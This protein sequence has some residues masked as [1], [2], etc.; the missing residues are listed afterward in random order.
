[1][2]VYPTEIIF[3][4]SVNMPEADSVTVGGAIDLTRRIVFADLAANSAVDFVSSS[5]ADTAVHVQVSG[6]DSGGVIQTPAFVTLTGTTKVTSQAQVFN[7]LLAGVA[8]GATATG[9]LANPGGTAA[10][11]DVAVLSRTL[12]IAAHA[13]QAGSANSTG[14]TPALFHLQSGDGSSLTLGMVIHTTGGTGANQLRRICSTSG[15]G[16]GQY[17]TDMVAINRDWA[18]VPDTTTTYEVATGF[19]FEILPDPVSSI[20]R[21]LTAAT[22]DIVGG[23]T[24]VY[25]EKIFAL[26][27]DLATTLTAASII[28]QTDPAGLYSGGGA[29]DFALCTALNDTATATNRQ[30]LPTGIGAFSSGAAPQSITCPN[31]LPFG[32]TPAGAQG[33]WLRLTLPPGEAPANTNFTLRATGTTT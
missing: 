11:G 15:T 18:V 22:S 20:V 21:P 12:T 3:C 28:K 29:L 31:N 9:P 10:V 32:N 14:V 17:G 6:R 23:S 2:S 13:A 5:A 1:M 33:V 8:S 16:S 24:H 30:T 4:G 19:L 7:R 25:Y 27:T 26:N